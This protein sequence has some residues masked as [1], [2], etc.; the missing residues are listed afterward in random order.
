MGPDLH[1]KSRFTKPDA[2]NYMEDSKVTA[3]VQVQHRKFDHSLK[4]RSQ[5]IIFT[6]QCVLNI[7]Q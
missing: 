4:H 3:T 5:K 2:K 6:A 1:S 7:V